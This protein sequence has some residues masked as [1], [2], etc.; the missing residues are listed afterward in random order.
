MFTGP[1]INEQIGHQRWRVHEGFSFRSST[2]LVVTVEKGFEHDFASIP[3]IVRG[4]ISKV[5][6]YSQAAIC[7]DLLYYRHR[8]G[9][10]TVITRLQADNILL[11]GCRVKAVDFS[12]PDSERRDWL[13]YGGVRIGGRDS[14]LSDKERAEIQS[15]MLPD[16][17][18]Q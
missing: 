10:D 17:Y 18:D 5:G 4:L 7:H 11:E 13:I 15:G 1:C 9:L 8:T 16:Y 12:V 14:W 3:A 2:G 6:Y